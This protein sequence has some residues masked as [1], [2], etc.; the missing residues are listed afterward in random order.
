MFDFLAAYIINLEEELAKI[1]QDKKVV[2]I[3][4]ERS[5]KWINSDNCELEK[6]NVAMTVI[7]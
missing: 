1:L 2:N 5:Q 4:T 3:I 7:S 6:V